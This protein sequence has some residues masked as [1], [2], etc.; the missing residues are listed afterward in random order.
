MNNK[1]IKMMFLLFSLLILLFGTVNAT[2][3]TD[4]YKTCCSSD[5]LPDTE[6]SDDII[7]DNKMLEKNEKII[8]NK[9]STKTSNRIP[10]K[11]SINPI[12]TAQYTDN[13]TISGNYRDVTG[14]I[15]RYTPL[16]VKINTNSYRIQTD[17]NGNFIE[18][19]RTNT[20]GTN[21]VSINYP[22][23]TRFEGN[24]TTKT[25]TVT[26]QDT[27]I[28]INP[29]E[30]AEYTDYITITGK[31]TDK[32]G[33]KLR[34]TPITFNINGNK[35]TTTTN[36][37]GEFSLNYK[38]SN[39]GINTVTALYPGNTRYYGAEET[40]YFIVTSKTTYIIIENVDDVQYSDFTRISGY[41][42]DKDY[43]P[44]RYTTLTVLINNDKYYTRT[45]NKGEF[46]FY[47]KTRK[48]GLNYVTVSY[49]GNSR[50]NSAYT[51]S[52]FDVTSKDTRIYLYASNVQYSDYT[53][54]YGNY[55][56]GRY[57]D[58]RYTPITLN[59]NGNKYITKTD[60]SGSFSF[61]YKTNKIGLN[62]VTASYP[63]NER[64][65][66]ASTTTKF[67][68]TPKDTQIQLVNIYD[69]ELINGYQT[70]FGNYTDTNGNPLRYTTLTVNNNGKKYYTKT[71]NMGRFTYTYKPESLAFETITVSYPGNERYTGAAT[72][73]KRSFFDTE[74]HL[75]SIEREYNKDFTINDTV[76]VKG[77]LKDKMRGYTLYGAPI[78]VTINEV[79]YDTTTENGY[80]EYTFKANRIGTNNITVS[81]LGD[82]RFTKS[83]NKTTFL[84]VGKPVIITVI[85]T[86]KTSNNYIKIEG[87]VYD[88]KGN[89]VKN[90]PLTLT[91]DN[92]NYYTQ[93]DSNGLY[94]Y[95][96]K[97]NNLSHHTL[98]VAFEGN[99]LYQQ[100]KEQITFTA[101]AN[102][103]EIEILTPHHR[104]DES[105]PYYVDVNSIKN[106]GTDV[107]TGW[108][109][110]YEGQGP[111]GAHVFSS[112]KDDIDEI[113]ANILTS[114]T[115]Y[116]K[117]DLNGNIIS[118]RG[119][120]E[121]IEYRADNINGY[122]PY[123]AI[124]KFRA[125]TPEEIKS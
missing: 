94:T 31:Y 110:K 90:I 7:P 52:T 61:N 64:F 5:T 114:V 112:G 72:S 71:D 23:N 16:N 117:N 39:V 15:L 19:F 12:E 22:G 42:K 102:E 28:T 46:T 2:D 53:V 14:R 99:S 18:K 83:Y 98:T 123:K 120:D 95:Y 11:I 122:T 68:V 50:Y 69:T 118:V 1:N 87:R 103:G 38:T 55:R 91:I 21:T 75:N 49:G 101:Y 100:N 66:G 86:V 43:N 67:Y 57:N 8:N 111:A 84:V 32:N 48:V 88:T 3:T 54:I 40:T 104:E 97:D 51:S 116:Y 106:I 85:N 73:T 10:T 121:N 47:Y 70:L 34:Y 37:Y 17:V 80:F 29:I 77:Y 9:T 107:L 24:T 92:N 82:D 115:F 96:Y 81:Y 62:N 6:L 125:R 89:M 76:T 108:Y 36:N 25:F 113:T 56:Y 20:V 60:E 105:D 26:R 33:V 65:S 124:V 13:I 4:E 27:N 30:T 74:L 78:K 41:Y 35:F 93:T 119:I 45:D 109:Q 58:L 79:T 59:I 63:G 44:L